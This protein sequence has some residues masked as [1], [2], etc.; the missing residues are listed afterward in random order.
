MYRF[1][2]SLIIFFILINDLLFEIRRGLGI[3]AP[4]SSDVED[5]HVAGIEKTKLAE[6]W[7][8]FL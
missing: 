4:V 8:Q 1:S 6:T 3:L 2:L 7:I 5:N